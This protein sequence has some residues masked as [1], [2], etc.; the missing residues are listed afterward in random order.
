MATKDTTPTPSTRTIQ[1]G[2]IAKF[3]NTQVYTSE[4]LAA[5][6]MLATCSGGFVAEHG[7]S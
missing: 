5:E 4:N 6:W 3:I 1:L 2:S 7:D